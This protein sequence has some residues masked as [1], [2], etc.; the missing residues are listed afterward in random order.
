MPNGKCPGTDGITVAIMKC[1]WKHLKTPCYEAIMAGINEG[2]LHD[3]A[4]REIINLIPKP[5][6]DGRRITNLHPIT[7]L[8]LDYKL[9]EKILANLMKTVMDQIIS[10][11]Q[12]GF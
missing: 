8:N 1:F 9:V 11:D 3:S 10:K 7:L 6:H 5:K 4:R 2:L 12:K